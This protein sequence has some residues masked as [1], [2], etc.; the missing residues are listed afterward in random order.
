MHDR[1][2]EG[3]E[4]EET[5]HS[6]K[7]KVYTLN[8]EEAVWKDLGLGMLR[9]KKHK[10]TGARRLLLRNSS[11]GKV[12]VVSQWRQLH[13]H[14]HV[15]H[16][17]LL[18]NFRLFAGMKASVTKQVI[19]LMGHDDKGHGVPFRLRFKTELAAYELKDVLD[20]ETPS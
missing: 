20:R 6:V 5:I 4:D 16:S 9:V 12:T 17:R 10:E 1:E 11:S 18:Q 2:G 13:F 8:K 19:S 14:T 15:E 7:T 3:E